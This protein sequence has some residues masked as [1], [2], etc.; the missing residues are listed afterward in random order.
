MQVVCT[1]AVCGFTD[2]KQLETLE[3]ESFDSLSAQPE[4]RFKGQ[5]WRYQLLELR[6][7]EVMMSLKPGDRLRAVH[8]ISRARRVCA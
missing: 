4:D 8:M 3:L 1:E 2:S 6:I 7:L 5:G